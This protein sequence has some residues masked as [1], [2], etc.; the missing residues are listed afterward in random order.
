MN[1]FKRLLGL[2]VVVLTMVLVVSCEEERILTITSEKTTILIGEATQLS[3][4]LKVKGKIVDNIADTVKFSSADE[5]ILNVSTTGYVTGLKAGN[6]AINAEVT[7]QKNKVKAK[8]NFIV[9]DP[10]YR[11]SNLNI[12]DG[13]LTW[14]SVTNASGYLVKVNGV[15]YTRDEVN[16]NLENLNLPI[17]NYEV[18]VFAK[19]NNELSAPATI[20]YVV[21]D[22]QLEA[23]TYALA[24]SGI[25]IN[26]TP[27]M[28]ETD[29]ETA[30]QY[31]EY[32]NFTKVAQAYTKGAMLSN[33]SLAKTT[34]FFAALN[35]LNFAHVENIED[36]KEQIDALVGAGLTPQ[37]LAS[38]LVEM[39]DTGLLVQA[40]QLV[41]I[42]NQYIINQDL[43]LASKVTYQEKAEYDL[44]IIGI[45]AYGNETDIFSMNN[46]LSGN[47]DLETFFDYSVVIDYINNDLNN[48]NY[49]MIDFYRTF[50]EEDET[51]QAI[52]NIVENAHF[53]EDQSFINTFKD[54]FYILENIR[55]LND[56]ID[57]LKDLIDSNNK[58]VDLVN[59]LQL[60]LTDNKNTY[61][62]SM[63]ETITYI[64]NIYNL[65]DEDFMG[66][67]NNTIND[68][69]PQV[70]FVLK[71][72]IVSLLK[73][74]LPTAL[75]F[76]QMYLA[77]VVTAN[78]A[79]EISPAEMIGFAKSLGESSN[80]S[81]SLLL[82][83]IDEFDLNDY[84]ELM[85][86]IDELVLYYDEYNYPTFDNRK[87][88]ELIVY[89]GKFKLDFENKH[90]ALIQQLEALNTE[91][92][93][94][95]T[96]LLVTGFINKVFEFSDISLEDSTLIISLL[97]K[98]D[99]KGISELILKYGNE[100]FEHF[101]TTNGKLALD[102]L[103]F[104]E[105][106]LNG[107][108]LEPQKDLLK[109]IGEEFFVYHSLLIPEL[110]DAE[111]DTLTDFIFD[112]VLLTAFNYIGENNP[113]TD[114]FEDFIDGIKSTAKTIIKNAITIEVAFVNALQENDAFY[115]FAKLTDQFDPNTSLLIQATL[116]LDKTLTVDNV[117][118]IK[119]SIELLYDSIKDNEL[120]LE[121][122]G[123]TPSDLA[124]FKV[125]L[126][127]QLDL[128]IID[129]TRV[130]QYD[131]YNLT[132]EQFNDFMQIWSA[133]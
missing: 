73:E 36:A 26:Y 108:L 11:P 61:R 115:E 125:M 48:G 87:I 56:E 28:K 35:G 8:L 113:Q 57:S 120:I 45:T 88:I 46:Y 1:Y 111:I 39:L 107:V 133:F 74:T 59:D 38:V 15:E 98:N 19:I 82:E 76:E 118:L 14:N 58:L 47:P 31:E 127:A 13:I 81:M 51:L 103:T 129:I 5:T 25:D 21:V 65:I 90:Q 114:D 86:I 95:Q 85:E 110:T 79:L 49:G 60:T 106:N 78:S 3:S 119:N 121:S 123:F 97:T 18:E 42:T 80:L 33:I 68:V 27:N 52:V 6:A 117:N 44:I 34:A 128:F 30:F 40:E 94:N 116:A 64:L 93:A 7:Y 4:T 22:K 77:F 89:I 99:L 131:F 20:T 67:L 83:L 32:V 29:F 62:A 66:S 63:T 105:N 17:G 101:V 23:D 91:A 41:K 130:S 12:A 96:E 122:L 92:F 75:E 124:E 43:Q 72:E 16:F 126:T 109:A 132:E 104:V 70:L 84:Q 53:N 54:N 9:K 10:A 71:G 69:N 37:Q 55:N 100:V 112:M 2:L 24:L 50:Y 102:L